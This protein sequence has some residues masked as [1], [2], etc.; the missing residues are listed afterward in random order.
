MTPSTA[1]KPAR[2]PCNAEKAARNEDGNLLCD[3]DEGHLP[4]HWDPEYGEHF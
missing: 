1:P 4:P 3:L 2:V